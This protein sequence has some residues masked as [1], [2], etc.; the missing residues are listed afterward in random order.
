[1]VLAD[2]GHGRN[3]FQRYAAGEPLHAQ[4]FTKVAHLHNLK[5]SNVP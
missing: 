1:V 4:V 5:T 2:F 3:V